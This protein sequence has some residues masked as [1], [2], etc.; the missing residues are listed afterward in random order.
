MRNLF[1]IL[2]FL[3]LP[4]FAEDKATNVV[5]IP[6]V[7]IDLA[8]QRFIPAGMTPEQFAQEEIARSLRAKEDSEYL[9]KF[10]A[11]DTDSRKKVMALIDKK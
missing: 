11:L 2:L 5:V 1:L 8:Y 10:K 3:G 4:I 9:R 7:V 6:T